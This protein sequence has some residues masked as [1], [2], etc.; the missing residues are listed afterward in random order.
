MTTIKLLSAGVIA[1]AM[2]TTP[3]MARN[4]YLAE[5]HIAGE[6]NTRTAPIP[7]YI[8]GRVGIRAPRVGALAAP[9]DGEN[10]DVGDNPSIC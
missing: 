8:H 4:N 3:V 2:L 10:C 7:R 6:A 9:P 5:R 1:A